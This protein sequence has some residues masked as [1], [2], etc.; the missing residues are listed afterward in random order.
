M[1][2]YI[3]LS[4]ISQ[5]SYPHLGVVFLG[6]LINFVFLSVV[7]AQEFFCTNQGKSQQRRQATLLPTIVAN[8]SPHEIKTMMATHRIVQLHITELGGIDHATIQT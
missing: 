2:K 8:G 3:S 1:S 7:L 6:L 5:L 4:G